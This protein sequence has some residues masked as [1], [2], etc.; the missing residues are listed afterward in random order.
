MSDKGNVF[1]HV[2]LSVH[3]ALFPL[4]MFKLVH[5]VAHASVRKRAVGI[6]LKCLLVFSRD[7]IFTYNSVFVENGNSTK[8]VRWFR[9]APCVFY[10]L[11]SL[12]MEGNTS[13]GKLRLLFY[14]WIE[15]F[16]LL[17]WNLFFCWAIM[18]LQIMLFPWDNWFLYPAPRPVRLQCS[19]QPAR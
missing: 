7:W 10:L 16:P 5:Y 17:E 11:R 2:C 15:N 13:A 9:R 12:L 8:R 1:S 19:I 6:R 3:W 4:S 18:Y 14:A